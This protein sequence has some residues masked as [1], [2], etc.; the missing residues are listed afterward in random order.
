MVTVVQQ[1]PTDG[2]VR[3]ATGG[4][5]AHVE[6]L[7]QTVL[8]RPSPVRF[9]FWD[10]SSFGGGETGGTW[11]CARPMRCAGCCGR[12]ASSGW[13]GPTSPATSTSRATSSPCSTRCATALGRQRRPGAPR[14]A[15]RRP[16]RRPRRLGVLGPPP[17]PPPEEARPPRP[18]ALASARDARRHPP[19]LRRRQR[20]LPAGARPVDDLL[21]RPV[22]SRRRTV[23]RGRPGGQARAGL[24]QARPARAPGMRLLDVGC[25]WGSMAHPRRRALRR[26]RSSAITIS[27][28]QADRAPAS[29]SPR[30]AWPTGSRSGCRTTATSR[31]RPFD[32][33]SSIGMFEH[34]GMRRDRPSTSTTL[35]APARARGPAAQPRHLPTAGGSHARP[36]ATLHRPLRVPRRRAARRRPTVVSRH[37]ASRLRGA[38]RRVAARA[39]RPHAARLGRQP[40]G[41]T[42]TRPWPLVGRRAGPGSG[43]STWRRRRSASRTGASRSTR[44]SASCPT[45]TAAAACPRPAATGADPFR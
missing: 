7:V 16:P 13:R 10:G 9:E 24:P 26:A 40:G 45:P 41:R 29:G 31:T 21:V 12:P 8:R 34:V 25:G 36:R 33:I 42:G 32:A 43:G 18:A 11:W 1:R 22:S 2:A 35:H 19:P 27:R 17:P 6:P 3:Q 23:A 30:P 37:G 39:L 5:A 4:A 28:Q 44:C 20:L 38:R 14:C 15:L